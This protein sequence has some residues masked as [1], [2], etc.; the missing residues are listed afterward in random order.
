MSG[1][2]EQAMRRRDVPWDAAAAAVAWSGLPGLALA[3]DFA[4]SD[5]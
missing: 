3:R 1:R 4:R 5:H 2:R